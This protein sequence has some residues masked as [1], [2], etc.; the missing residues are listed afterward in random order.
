MFLLYQIFLN[1][2]IK[3]AFIP[4]QNRYTEHILLTYLMATFD[5]IFFIGP[6]GSGK[7]TQARLVAQRHNFHY[8]E[9]GGML[10][11]LAKRKPQWG[12]TSLMSLMPAI[13]WRTQTW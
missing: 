11:A 2:K 3:P 8:W 7:G 13:C 4:L 9:M 12:V 6:Q 1:I 5:A 10:R